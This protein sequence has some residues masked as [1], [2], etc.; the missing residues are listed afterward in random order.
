[1][2][3]GDYESQEELDTA[4]DAAGKKLLEFARLAQMVHSQDWSVPL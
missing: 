2:T 1:M 3:V 4:A